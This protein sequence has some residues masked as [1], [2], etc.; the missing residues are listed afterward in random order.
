VC[1]RHFCPLH[2]LKMPPN[3]ET[4]RSETL[5]DHCLFDRSRTNN[6]SRSTPLERIMF[7]PGFS[8]KQHFEIPSWRA[9]QAGEALRDVRW[10][11]GR[12]GGGVH[13]NGS[14][15]QWAGGEEDTVAFTHRV[16]RGMM[17][18][19]V[20]SMSRGRYDGRRAVRSD[21]EA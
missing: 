9:N 21:K 14:E 18:V 7:G 19:S 1:S 20:S 12:R 8:N 4:S 15:A 10:H 6:V 2:N 3:E 11:P 5:N 16:V 17:A 13:R